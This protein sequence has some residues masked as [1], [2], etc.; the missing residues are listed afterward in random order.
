[1]LNLAETTI[2]LTK[3]GSR[4]YGTSIPSSDL[5]I[6]GVLIPPKKYYYGFI[7]N[8]HQVEQS[9]PNDLVVYE[10][11]KFFK[12][13][14]QCN[15]NIIEVLHTDE[16][17]ILYINPLGEELRAYGSKFLSQRAYKTFT[18]YANSQLKRIRGHNKWITDPPENPRESG[19][20]S[21]EGLLKWK[22]Y[23]NW[24][25]N[26]NLARAELE[27]KF[28]Y[29]TKHAMHLV[30]LLRM[31]EEILKTGQVLVKRPDA[32]ELLAI[33]NGS[34]SYEDLLKWTEEK[35]QELYEYYQKDK[36]PL[37]QEPNRKELN[38]ACIRL[39]EHALKSHKKLW[40]LGK[41]NGQPL[42]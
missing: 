3:H 21:D 17:D 36:S 10:I 18:G 24:R 38:E 8:V 26:R 35:D 19:E 2:Y 29:D 33:R 16:S 12:L 7:D 25:K 11:R 23:Q 28:G 13:A 4:A 1:M 14:S 32:E 6:K 27:E 15:P 9:E 41:W 31:G 39:T 40:S 34:W 20:T 30:R 5:D 22:Q 37:P 42:F